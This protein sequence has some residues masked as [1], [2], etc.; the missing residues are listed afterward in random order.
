MNNLGQAALRVGVES[1]VL[2][3]IY[4]NHV[5]LRLWDK[6]E[7]DPVTKLVGNVARKSLRTPSTVQ[8]PATTKPD[9]PVM[10][11]VTERVD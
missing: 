1:R 3:M 10:E 9:G 4:I 7:I 2:V 11:T 6:Q 8:W 5:G